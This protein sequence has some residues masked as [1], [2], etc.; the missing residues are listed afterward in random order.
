MSRIGI[1]IRAM[2]HDADHL[3]TGRHDQDQDRVAA[4]WETTV[5]GLHLVALP[6]RLRILGQVFEAG[7]KTLK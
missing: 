6:T 2:V 4:L 5:V 3:N 7:E 1:N